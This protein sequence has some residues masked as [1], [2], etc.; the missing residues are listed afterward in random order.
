MCVCVQAVSIDHFISFPV[1][2]DGRLRAHDSSSISSFILFS[3]LSSIIP[4]L[5]GYRC[6]PS[7]GFRRV[8]RVRSNISDQDILD[9]SRNSIRPTIC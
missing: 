3:I 9:R 1:I 8:I 5:Y 6:R 7:A 2:Y 4:R